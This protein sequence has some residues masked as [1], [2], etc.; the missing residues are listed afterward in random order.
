M[1]AGDSVSRDGT[2]EAQSAA[3]A[4]FIG[5]EEKALEAAEGNTQVRIQG[6]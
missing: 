3:A 4:Q 6:I 1:R 2:D 5:A